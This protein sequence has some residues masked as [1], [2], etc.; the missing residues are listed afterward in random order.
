M[1]IC[2]ALWKINELDQSANYNAES[3]NVF[4]KL[5]SEFAMK[6]NL[7]LAQIFIAAPRS[8]TYTTT[9]KLSVP[10]IKIDRFMK[11]LN[12]RLETTQ[13]HPAASAV[14]M[15]RCLQYRNNTYRFILYKS[16]LN[17]DLIL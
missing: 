9:M 4:H 3:H 12:D 16:A 5:K 8:P 7:D 10:S 2:F 17:V 1:E 13:G 14:L 11:H 6:L 15:L